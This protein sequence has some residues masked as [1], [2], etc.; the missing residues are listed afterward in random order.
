VSKWLDMA[1]PGDRYTI[2]VDWGRHEDFT[3]FA[4]LDQHQALVH[5]DR[6]TGI[7]YELQV[8]RLTALWQRFG[9][10]PILAESNSM[11]GPLI[12]RLQ[13]ARITVRAF[14]TTNA[15][16]AQAIEALS[17]GIENRQVALPADKRA[18]FLRA[19]LLAYEQER[20]PSGMIRYGAPPGQHDDGVMA[21]AIA[22][23]GAAVPIIEPG[24]QV[25]GL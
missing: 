7:G 23:H 4:V 25:A 12:E 21:L 6:F 20:L 15:S 3:V 18:D 17:L 11:G 8:G 22:Y 5:V 1:G 2:G 10:P 24:M 13:R 16:K 19:E 14:H 9:C